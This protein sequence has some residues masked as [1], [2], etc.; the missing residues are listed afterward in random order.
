MAGVKVQL[1]S[2]VCGYPV[3]PTP[4]VRETVLSSLS[5]LGPLVE[6]DL[7]IYAGAY[8]WTFYPVPLVHMSLLM[9]GTHRFAV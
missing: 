8:F 4:F 3:S 2:F 1:R 9:S 7:T 6:D 5:G